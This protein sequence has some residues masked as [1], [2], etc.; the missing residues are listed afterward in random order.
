MAAE[1]PAIVRPRTTGEL[2]DDAWR[3]Y[4]ADAPL[5]QLLSGLFL[6]PAFGALLLLAGLP[7]P[8]HPA[9]RLLP[10]LLPLTLLVLTGLGAG[11]CQE[12]FRAR[13]EA[14]LPSLSGCLTSAFRRGLSHAAARAAA[15]TG[16]FLALG[17]GIWLSSLLFAD[18]PGGSDHAALLVFPALLTF[19]G[20][21]TAV[22]L[23]PLQATIHAFLVS[24]KTRS[25]GDLGE[26]I[27]QARYD[28][29]KTGVVTLSR[30][31]LLVLA[32]VN[33]HLL[34][35]AGLFVLGDLAGF[36][37]SFV[38]LQL[39]LTNPLYD[40]ALILLAWL[41]LA[42]FFEACNYLMHMDARARQEGLDLQLQVQSV[43]PQGER[44]RIGALAVLLGLGF[45]AAIPAHAAEDMQY[46]AVHAARMD[47]ER[48]IQAAKAADPYNGAH[49]QIELDQTAGRLER[50]AGRGRFDW[51]GQAIDGFSQRPKDDA[52]ILL[53]TLDDRL[54]LLEETLPRP[55]D[56]QK[57]PSRD[58]LKGLLQQ[59]GANRPIVDARPED[60]T[61][62]PKE[63]KQQEEEQK[64]PQDDDQENGRSHQALMGPPVIPG[65]GQTA[66]MLLAGLG[67]AVVVVGA[68]L[69]IA[70]RSKGPR[71][72]RGPLTPSKTMKQT[73][74]RHEPPPT[75]RS[76]AEL[77][78]EA[79]EQARNEQHLQAVRTLYLAVLSLLHRRQ[80]LRFE[81]MRTNGEYIQ[82]V[83][84]APQ[85]PAALHTVFQQFTNLFERK[86]YGDRACD[87]AE[88]GACRKL[89]EE[90][91][92]EVREM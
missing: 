64:D 5:L 23:W 24:G 63:R 45:L 79:E 6:A 30:L 40:L 25:L 21:A 36:D 12:W 84:L 57:A 33:L 89:A 35:A 46:D 87:A 81:P 58:D 50:S 85:A 82:Q 22:L 53:G 42:P 4:F 18:K 3:L 19:A 60:E 27:R 15:L 54:A 16:A 52:L 78:R 47:L 31:A 67:L 11:A 71:P 61:D 70:S 59:P 7:A 32:V 73:T 66:L 48:I 8:T 34:V 88:F 77:W 55:G 90:I 13:T 91:Q 38:A 86:W 1:G 37:A 9:L 41:L 17:P 56:E 51:F 20:A 14:K 2:L 83:R 44:R 43:F 69:F 26:Y 10:P 62:K 80:L 72:P 76:A 92:S 75:E 68:V 39:T 28:T 65:C 49:V 74:E 29:T